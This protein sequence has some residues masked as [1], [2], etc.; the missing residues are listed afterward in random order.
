MN[1][2]IVVIIIVI[3]LLLF[4]FARGVSYHVETFMIND[5]SLVSFNGDG[6]KVAVDDEYQDYLKAS[7]ILKE[8]VDRLLIFK[9][10]LKL[11]YSIKSESKD[12]AQEIDRSESLGNPYSEYQDGKN[13][14]GYSTTMGSKSQYKRHVL[15]M[16]YRFLKRFDPNSLKELPPN[17][18]TGETAYTENKGD[19]IMICI[20]SKDGK[21]H[22]INTVMY[23]LLHECSHIVTTE[24]DHPPVFWS[25]FK[26]VLKNAV[27]AGIYTPEDYSKGNITYCGKKITYN[28]L[29]NWKD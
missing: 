16:V 17:S 28:P 24:L 2:H 29:F 12:P 27:Q 1:L 14:S 19:R 9:K 18:G 21:L 3:L 8:S 6:F 5:K 22:N 11:K 15:E 4:L 20:R 10:F 7:N 25:N 13:I 23:V 26:F